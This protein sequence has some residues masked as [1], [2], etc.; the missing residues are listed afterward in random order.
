MGYKLIVSD[1]DE[2]LLND[3]REI[4]ENNLKMIKL[5]KEKYGVRFVPATGRGYASIQN[6]LAKLGLHDLSGEYTISYNG[7]IITEN[8]G[9]TLLRSNGLDYNIMKKI[10]E[11]GLT[12]DLC[13]HVYTKD[14]VYVFNVNSYEKERMDGY[15]GGRVY[16]EENS[17]DF[18]KN[19][20]IYKILFQNTNI[21]YLM[22]LEEPMKNLT[23][24]CAVSYSSNR[25]M[26][27]NAMG[28]DKGNGL[29][30]LADILGID[31]KDTIAVGD[32]YNDIPMLK[33]AGLSVAVSNAVDDAKK[34]AHYVTEADNNKGAVAELI[35][36]FIINNI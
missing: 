4:S 25:Y 33:T 32:N 28:I 2:T 35:E 10:F 7:A 17:V 11:F 3:N 15:N 1:M 16:V 24:N 34:A 26:E 19:E 21:P 8:K 12:K 5:A 36:K 31:V 29:R 22:S 27:F 20:K 14:T 9:N 30:T 18:L 23:E 13:Q 6:E